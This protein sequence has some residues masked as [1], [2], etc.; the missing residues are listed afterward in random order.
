K[1]LL[2]H[3]GAVSTL[4]ALADGEFDT[5]I[6]DG[7]APQDSQKVLLCSGKVYYDLEK[8][9]AE[10]NRADVAIVRIEQ[11]YPVP[12]ERLRSALERYPDGTPVVWIQE[13]PRNMGAA[14]FWHLQL[15]NKLFDR[16][17]FSVVARDA[18]AS[19]ATGSASRHHQQQSELVAAAFG[20]Q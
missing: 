1:S 7:S 11:F 20:T 5:V 16:F 9:R 6:A 17:P 13:E 14:C 19:P 3:P 15:G 2:R 12:E 10:M 18:S 8:K 4:D